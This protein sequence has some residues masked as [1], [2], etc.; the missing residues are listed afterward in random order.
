MAIVVGF[1]YSEI[2]RIPLLANMMVAVGSASIVLFPI[3]LGKSIP[4]Q[5][6]LGFLAIFAI[7]WSGDIVKDLEDVEIDRGHKWTIPLV[8]GIKP[9]KI[10]VLVLNVATA[11]LL[12]YVTWTGLVAAACF[13]VGSL[14]LL[15]KGN[16][17]IT[18]HIL[19]AG[20]V[21]A[22]LAFLF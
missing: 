4:H 20:R 6:W 16:I 19:H 15:Y 11:I 18:K 22:L 3:F 7:A 21:T 1:T 17:P 12:V 8:W 9:T 5:L 13:V 2:L 14:F 10:A